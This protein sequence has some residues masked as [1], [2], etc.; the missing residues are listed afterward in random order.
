MEDSAVVNDRI[1]NDRR[2]AVSLARLLCADELSAVWVTDEGH[3]TMRDLVRARHAAAEDLAQGQAADPG[4]PTA[5]RTS[6]RGPALEERCMRS[7]SAA[8]SLLTQSSISHSRAIL[9]A[10]RTRRLGATNSR[11][12]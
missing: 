9:A 10:P 6:L 2:H 3:G 1:K 8:N 11:D 5:P 12:R 4:V 7:G